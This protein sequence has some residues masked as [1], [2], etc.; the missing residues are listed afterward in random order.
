[1]KKKNMKN[2]NIVG[3]F[4]IMLMAST[5]VMPMPVSAQ[6]SGIPVKLGV[7]S[8]TIHYHSW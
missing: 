8:G 7:N 3:I 1:M 6:N 5:F 2:K 4:A